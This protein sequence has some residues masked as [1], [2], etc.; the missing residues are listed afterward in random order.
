MT[1]IRFVF[2]FGFVFCFL[3][4]LFFVLFYNN[5]MWKPFQYQQHSVWK[6]SI[7][8]GLFK[9]QITCWINYDQFH[10]D[11]EFQYAFSMMPLS[12][13][14]FFPRYW[15]FVRGMLRSPVNSPHKGQWLGALM[16]SFI[17]AW[18]HGWVKHREAGELRRHRAHYDVI[19]MSWN[20]S[21]RC[22]GCHLQYFRKAYRIKF[23]P[24]QY[25]SSINIPLNIFQNS[26]KLRF[27][28]NTQG[29]IFELGTVSG[30]TC[31]WALLIRSCQ[32]TNT[33]SYLLWTNDQGLL[34][35]HVTTAELSSHAQICNLFWLLLLRL[36]WNNFYDIG[37]MG[38]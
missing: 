22:S 34:H 23:G 31:V 12:N 16:F 25:F 13:G 21:C 32:I 5:V 8:Y 1:I 4:C 30:N 11:V 6:S 33:S 20:A 14:N 3:L 36:S 24:F 29:P 38:S 35:V 18:I 10:G 37:L 2:V 7:V 17:C 28:S 19:V 9:D 26:L 15:P 27:F